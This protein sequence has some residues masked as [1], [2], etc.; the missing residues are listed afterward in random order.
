MLST[1]I[2]SSTISRCLGAL[3]L[4]AGVIFYIPGT[5]AQTTSNTQSVT[6]KIDFGDGLIWHYRN[7]PFKP[8]MTIQDAMNQL[9][10]RKIHPLAFEFSG[11]GQNAFLNSI[12]GIE[13]EGGGK[14]SRNWFYRIGDKLG[15]RSFGIAE[16]NAGDEVIWHYGKYQPE[17]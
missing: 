17:K 6:L 11:R 4:A 12:A 14:S 13:N 3:I 1:S 7:I 8:K 9:S 5:S 10:G 15:D 16:L 2:F